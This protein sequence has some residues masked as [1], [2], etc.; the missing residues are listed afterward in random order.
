MCSCQSLDTSSHD[1]GHSLFLELT[2][3]PA[4][5]AHPSSGLLPDHDNLRNAARV[6]GGIGVVHRLDSR[7]IQIQTSKPAEKK[8]SES[9]T[10][11]EV[12]AI[13]EVEVVPHNP[14]TF[15]HGHF[16]GDSNLSN[17]CLY[18]CFSKPPAVV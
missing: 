3:N 8:N 2:T 14:Y 12:W 13:D 16:S 15:P 5:D 17:S 10:L 7:A 18:G 11:R 4:C 9:V 1:F 6:S